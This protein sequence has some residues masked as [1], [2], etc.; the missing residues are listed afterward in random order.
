MDCVY[1]IFVDEVAMSDIRDKKMIILEAASVLFQQYGYA[2]TS[3]DEIAKAAYIGKGTIYYYFSDKEE[4]FVEVVRVFTDAFFDQLS[5]LIEAENTFEAKFT[6]YLRTPI[7]LLGEH[8]PVLAEAFRSLSL[9]HQSK[10]DV[11]RQENKKRIKEIFRGILDFGAKQGIISEELPLDR[12]MDIIN[13]W[14]LLG[15]DNIA[16][17]NK[18]KLIQKITRDHEWIIKIILNGILKRG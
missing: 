2:K 12:F 8:V 16:V 17:V 1:K 7:K 3:L 6:V 5:A 13:D 14:F 18:E 10:I 15:D 4:I 9:M 11:F